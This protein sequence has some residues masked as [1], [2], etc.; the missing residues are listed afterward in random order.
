MAQN[1]IVGCGRLAVEKVRSL[2]SKR[3][4]PKAERD[5]FECRNGT[6]RKAKN[7]FQPRD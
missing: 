5:R 3:S 6:C 4:P 7:T 2:T 1:E